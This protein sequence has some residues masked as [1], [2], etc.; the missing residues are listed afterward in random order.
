MYHLHHLVTQCFVRGCAVSPEAADALA[1]VI[2]TELRT[3]AGGDDLYI[4]AAEKRLRDE[5]IRREFNGRN[6]QEVRAKHGLSARQI[7]RIVSRKRSS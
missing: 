3:L 6:L 2:V 1:L 7:Y 4:P 5:S